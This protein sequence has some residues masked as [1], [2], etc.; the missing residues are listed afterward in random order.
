MPY[1]VCSL[2]NQ[3]KELTQ[4]RFKHKQNCYVARCKECEKQLLY[5]WRSSNLD[6]LHKIYKRSYD[7]N[8]SKWK[9]FYDKRLRQQTPPWVNKQELKQIYKNRPKGFH[10]DHIVP[11]KGNNVSGLHVPWNLQYLSATENLKKG[12][13][14][15]SRT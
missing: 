3:E 11:L 12:R 7:K 1:K 5:Q 15:I 8:K 4:F 9:R 10:V 14:F 13:I 6:N 2:C